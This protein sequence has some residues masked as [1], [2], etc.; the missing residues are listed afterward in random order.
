MSDLRKELYRESRQMSEAAIDAM[1]P[2]AAYQLGVAFGLQDAARRIESAAF[3]DR[4]EV[5]FRP[6]G[7]P[8]DRIASLVKSLKALDTWSRAG[9]QHLRCRDVQ[10]VFAEHGLTLELPE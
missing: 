8:E 6:T 1:Q 2:K 10:R 7:I 3:R 9:M 4:C 5:G